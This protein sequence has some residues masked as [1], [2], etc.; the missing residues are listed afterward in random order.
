[1]AKEHGKT[2][3]RKD[4][5]ERKKEPR[6]MS[7]VS[8]SKSVNRND[9]DVHIKCW[10]KKMYTCQTLSR[11]R[12]RKFS[13]FCVVFKKKKNEERTYISTWWHYDVPVLH[14]NRSSLYIFYLSQSTS[15]FL[16]LSKFPYTFFFVLRLNEFF[17]PQ[18][19]CVFSLDSEFELAIIFSF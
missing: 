13:C 16:T 12:A 3:E 2:N 10:N 18:I 1:M 19:N 6:Q 15:S 9:A 14:I 7:V 5:K 17:F 11:S 4:C 8:I